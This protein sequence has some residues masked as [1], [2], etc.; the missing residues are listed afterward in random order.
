MVL[1]QIQ[2]AAEQIAGRDVQVVVISTE[3]ILP[4]RRAEILRICVTREI[5]LLH[6]AFSLGP[7]VPTRVESRGAG[8]RPEC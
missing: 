3:R 5:E 2:N 4:H 1:G 6:F 7:I 8:I